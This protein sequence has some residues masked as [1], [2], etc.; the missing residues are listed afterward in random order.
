MSNIIWCSV[1][2]VKRIVLQVLSQ[3]LNPIHAIILPN[4]SLFLHRWRADRQSDI[5]YSVFS[6][7]DLTHPTGVANEDTFVFSDPIVSHVAA[8]K[9]LRLT[10]KSEHKVWRC[11]NWNFCTKSHKLRDIDRASDTFLVGLQQRKLT[12]KSKIE[13]PSTHT[14]SLSS[15]SSLTFS[16]FIYTFTRFQDCNMQR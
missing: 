7:R 2:I 5:F 9:M 11:D 4:Y 12:L 10:W 13:S 8:N 14:H 15:S 1:S 16:S 6:K 3:W